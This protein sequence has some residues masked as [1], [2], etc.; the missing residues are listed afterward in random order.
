MIF[1]YQPRPSFLQRMDAV[2]KLVWLIVV[3][4]FVLLAQDWFINA[5][6]ATKNNQGRTGRTFVK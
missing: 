1:V 2:S 5:C 6:E 4:A 3:G